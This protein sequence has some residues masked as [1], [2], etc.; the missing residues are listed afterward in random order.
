MKTGSVVHVDLASQIIQYDSKSI[1]FDID[2]SRKKTLLEGLDDI[3]ITLQRQDKI[4]QFE[5]NHTL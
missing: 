2:E 4:T 5:Q 3:A 1:H